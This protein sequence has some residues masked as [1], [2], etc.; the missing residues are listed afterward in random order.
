MDGRGEKG[1]KNSKKGK[2]GVFCDRVEEREGRR[3]GEEGGYFFMMGK[4]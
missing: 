2:E 1:E 3:S 4:C